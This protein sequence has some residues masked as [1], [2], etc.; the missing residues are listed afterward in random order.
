MADSGWFSF[1]IILLVAAF[2]FSK[3]LL[4]YAESDDS[5]AEGG[6]GNVSR[7][8]MRP[9]GHSGKAKKGHLCFDA[10]F[11]TGGCTNR[12]FISHNTLLNEFFHFPKGNLGKVD[13]VSD[14]EYD[15]YIRPDTCNPYHRMWFNFVVDNTKLDQVFY[16]RNTFPTLCQFIVRSRIF[17]RRE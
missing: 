16:A 10:S 14:F 2:G 8:V 3:Y 9:P 5:D 6:L 13:L 12:N 7:I 11:E 15:L 4:F 1:R 17:F